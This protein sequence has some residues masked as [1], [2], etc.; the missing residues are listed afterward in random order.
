MH[1]NRNQNDKGCLFRATLGKTQSWK[2]ETHS[3]P[4]IG[5]AL[6]STQ[7]KE[8]FPPVHLGNQELYTV[9]LLSHTSCV[10]LAGAGL[11]V[12]GR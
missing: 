6:V 9:Q 10:K 11:G 3:C 12:G 5:T 4:M 8:M 1:E 7:V 2:T